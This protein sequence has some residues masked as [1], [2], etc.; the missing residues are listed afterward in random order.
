[1]AYEIAVRAAALLQRCDLRLLDAGS[2]HGDGEHGQ[3]AG[4]IEN[5][6]CYAGRTVDAPAAPTSVHRP[7][8][9]NSQ[10]TLLIFS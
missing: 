1:M 4:S 10:R 3:P 6:C 5:C 2:L 8:Q 7:R 9:L